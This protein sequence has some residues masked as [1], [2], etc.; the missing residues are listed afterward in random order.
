[1]SDVLSS[2]A[3]R[4]LKHGHAQGTFSIQSVGCSTHMPNNLKFACFTVW[5]SRLRIEDI[6]PKMAARSVSTLPK[7]SKWRTPRNYSKRCWLLVFA[8]SGV[9][10]R[11]HKGVHI[12]RIFMSSTS[13]CMECKTR[14]SCMRPQRRVPRNCRVI[15]HYNSSSS[16]LLLEKMP[17]L[18][19][20]G[21]AHN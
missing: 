12:A 16:F 8:C 10:Y 21:R 14:C 7:F 11:R 19:P 2:N 15:T 4:I 20:S 5:K 17:R 18:D 9:M 6:P 1:M 13:R 3:K